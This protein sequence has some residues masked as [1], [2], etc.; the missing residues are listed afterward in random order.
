M[1]EKLVEN[2]VS[3]SMLAEPVGMQVDMP[4]DNP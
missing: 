2:P 4:I 1:N 3:Q